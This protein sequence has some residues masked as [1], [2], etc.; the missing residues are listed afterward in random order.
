MVFGEWI[1]V[2]DKLP[3][4]GENVWAKVVGEWDER[5]KEPYGSEMSYQF[6]DRTNHLAWLWNTERDVEYIVTHWCSLSDMP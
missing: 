5:Y 4:Q 3:K 2:K 6:N 1:S